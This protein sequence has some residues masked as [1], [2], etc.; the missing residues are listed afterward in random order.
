MSKLTKKE[1]DEKLKKSQEEITEEVIEDEDLKKSLNENLETM[2]EL[3][4]YNTKTQLR[5]MMKNAKYRKMM[6]DEM[7]NY[8]ED[9]EEDEENE[10]KKSLDDVIESNEEVIDAVPVLKSFVEVL[11]KAT[12]KIG[13]LTQEV[14]ELKNNHYYPDPFTPADRLQPTSRAGDHTG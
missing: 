3:L 2:D 8:K 13:S 1:N 10:V 5:E 6:A 7:K 12:D 11:E 9:E 4:K 14:N